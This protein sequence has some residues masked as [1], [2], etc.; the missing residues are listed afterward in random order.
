M[1]VDHVA[2]GKA[3]LFGRQRVANVNKRD[4]STGLT[5]AVAAFPSPPAGRLD[6]EVRLCRDALLYGDHVDLYS[7]NHW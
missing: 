4:R 1:A 2:A 3:M 5:I 7:A 6:S